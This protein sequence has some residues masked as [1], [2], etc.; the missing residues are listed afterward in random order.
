[1]PLELITGPMFSGK[2]E[3][4]LRRLK[5]EDIAGNSVCL[6][7]WAKDTRHVDAESISTH[8]YVAQRKCQHCVERLSDIDEGLLEQADVLAIDEGQFFGDLEAFCLRWESTKKIVVSALNGSYERK[9]WA[10][11]SALV[12]LCDHL[13]LY[14]AICVRCK[15]SDA[16]FSHRK[17]AAS[18]DTGLI[19]LVGGKETYEPLCRACFLSAL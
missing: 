17:V 19:P 14:H 2:T 6:I 3:E 1:M 16:I 13:D 10:Q 8:D 7:K 15:R 12:A 9:P 5:R 4:L 11:V 18:L